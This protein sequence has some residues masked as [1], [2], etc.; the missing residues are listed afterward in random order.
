MFR[1]NELKGA[2]LEGLYVNDTRGGQLVANARKQA[3]EE[4]Y[5]HIYA[6]AKAS[7]EG[8][9]EL[10]KKVCDAFREEQARRMRE[11]DKPLF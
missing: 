6:V 2:K 3:Q 9:P 5:E 8:G 11:A 7:V 1:F 4:Y 10:A